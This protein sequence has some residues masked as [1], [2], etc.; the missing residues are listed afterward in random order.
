[1]LNSPVTD[2]LVDESRR[3]S[4]LS[5][6]I[7]VSQRQDINPIESSSSSSSTSPPQV[8]GLKLKN[9]TIIEADEYVNAMPV[10]VFK[11]L[12][13]GK[14]LITYHIIAQYSTSFNIIIIIIIIIM[15]TTTTIIIL[16]IIITFTITMMM[17]ELWSN[18]PYFRQCDMLEGIPVINIQIWFDKKLNSID[19]LVF[20]RSPL[21]SV[22]ADMSTC[23]KEY[24]DSEKSMLELVFAP[25]SK[26]AASSASASAV[27]WMA[28]TDSEIFDATVQELSRLFPEEIS[29]SSSSP[30]P[31]GSGKSYA[32]VLKYSIVRTPRSVYAAVPGR[33][34]YRPT[35]K[36]PGIYTFLYF[37]VYIPYVIIIYY[38]LLIIT[39]FR[40]SHWPETGHPRNS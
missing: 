19:G 29:S 34:K 15:T 6:Q 25:C 28:K 27:N 20:S 10:D 39:K 4:I 12:L 32:K 1:M 36:S 14:A 16:T 18:I 21:L 3:S 33:N 8:V 22:Y 24:E 40:I 2:I 17:T 37:T 13:P 38:T 26:E 30:S 23:C 5:H 9:G 11:R 35:Q 7:A 31:Q